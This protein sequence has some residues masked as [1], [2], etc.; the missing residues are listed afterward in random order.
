MTVSQLILL[1]VLGE[2][3][4]E[5]IKLIWE[6][7][8]INLDRAG[9][10]LLGVILA[11]GTGIDFFAMVGLPIKIAYVGSVLTGIILSRGSNFIHDLLKIIE[12]VKVK[13]KIS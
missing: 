6:K 5:S 11:L 1:A 4:W 8:H 7:K 9:S 12:G 3:I 10:L 13:N 2:R